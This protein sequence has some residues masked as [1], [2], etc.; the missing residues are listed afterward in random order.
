[1]SFPLYE[2]LSDLSY[3]GESGFLFNVTD[4][5][6]DASRY[7]AFND[8]MDY[9]DFISPEDSPQSADPDSDGVVGDDYL[10]QRELSETLKEFRNNLLSYTDT[11]TIVLI[12]LYVPT[13]MTALI[14]NILVLLVVL[15]NRHM[16]NVTNC[17]I[18][19]LA[20]A[21]LLVPVPGDTKDEVFTDPWSALIRSSH[22]VVHAVPDCCK[23]H[24]LWE[25]FNSF[26]VDL[27]RTPRCRLK[28]NVV[29]Y[30]LDNGR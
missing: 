12:C 4:H 21:D 24:S 26:L 30:S 14:G 3:S 7:R 1:M 16:R 2:K 10:D 5:D 27:M 28:H 20:V 18:V 11:K 6:P 13:F 19:N 25:V 23:G 8:T 15:P 22:D 17:F 9:L 29:D